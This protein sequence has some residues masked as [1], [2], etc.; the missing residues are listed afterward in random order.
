MQSRF[1]NK[2]KL[3]PKNNTNMLLESQ[4]KQEAENRSEYRNFKPVKTMKIQQKVQQ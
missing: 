2:N 4:D 3:H 1:T